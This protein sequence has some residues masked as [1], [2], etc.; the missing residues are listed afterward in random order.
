MNALL[1]MSKTYTFKTEF[2]LS[3]PFDISRFRLS[4]VIQFQ[5]NLIK[6]TDKL[7]KCTFEPLSSTHLGEKYTLKTIFKNTMM[8]YGL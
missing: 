1:G 4:I 2:M 5:N 6:T 7:V 8:I 3:S